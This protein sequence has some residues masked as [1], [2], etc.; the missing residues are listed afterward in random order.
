MNIDGIQTGAEKKW[1]SGR[2]PGLVDRTIDHDPDGY[3]TE[4]IV[5]LRAMERRVISYGIERGWCVGEVECWGG[6]WANATCQ[7]GWFTED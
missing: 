5:R 6:C 7:R 2:S 4:G 1:A 3:V